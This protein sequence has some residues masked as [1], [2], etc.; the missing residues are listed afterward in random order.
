MSSTATFMICDLRFAI[1]APRR[2][3]LATIVHR[4]SSIVNSMARW[5][6]CNILHVAPDA[7]R[8]WQFDAKGG[9]FVLEPR[10]ARAARRTRCRPRASPKVVFAVAAEVERR[11]AAGGKRFSPRRRTAG[12]Q[13]RGDAGDGGVAAG[14]IFA[15]C[16]SR[17]SSGRCM[18]WHA[19][20]RRRRR[21]A[22]SLQT[23]VVVIV[24]RSV[25]GGISRQA[26]EGRLS[27]R[28]AGSADAG[29][30]GGGRLRDRRRRTAR[31][32]F[33]CRWAAR[34]PRWWRGGLA[35]RCGI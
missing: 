31:G 22:E 16:R 30:I 2:G 10:A 28:P 19:P 9:G 15:D 35:A 24:E 11:V 3:E 6:S 26:G 33:R 21:H 4:Q 20:R 1:C 25:G 12:E 13:F 18:S 8:L 23:V 29:P 7:K 32:F 27:R 5:N 34:T 14:K 17:K